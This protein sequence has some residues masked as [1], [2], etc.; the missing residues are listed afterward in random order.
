MVRATFGLALVLLAAC[1][2]EPPRPLTDPKA[3]AVFSDEVASAI[4]VQVSEIH[5]RAVVRDVRLEGPEDRTVSGT[6]VVRVVHKPEGLPRPAFELGVRGGTSG[7]IVPGVG[8]SWSPGSGAWR[9]EIWIIPLPA[10]LPRP[11]D[12]E[13]WRIRIDYLDFEGLARYL[14][15]DLPEPPA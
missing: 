12:P 8:I 7:K 1:A 5:P 9:D 14:K 6:P 3:V 4:E 13:D 2:G 10:S 11:I 15:L